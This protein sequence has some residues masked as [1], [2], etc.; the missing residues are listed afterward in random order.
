VSATCTK[1]LALW[2]SSSEEDADYVSLHHLLTLQNKFLA[3][4]LTVLRT[5]PPPP[6]SLVPL[7][8]ACFSG[9]QT[10]SLLNAAELLNPVSVVSFRR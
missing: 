5:P 2:S 4:F 10:A 9:S 8:C 3:C 1:G 6:P 7:C